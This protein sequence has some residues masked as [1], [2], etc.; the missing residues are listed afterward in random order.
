MGLKISLSLFLL[1]KKM[2]ILG[3]PRKLSALFLI[4]SKAHLR[5]ISY[6]LNELINVRSAVSQ[7]HSV[8]LKKISEI[9]K[10]GSSLCN[11]NRL[12]A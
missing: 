4:S 11:P 1:Y 5:G 9:W 2:H 7:V 3:T 10:T 12:L 6:Q 8:K